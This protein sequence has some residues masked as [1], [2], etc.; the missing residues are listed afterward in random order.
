MLLLMDTQRKQL[1]KR[2]NGLI[3]KSKNARTYFDLNWFDRHCKSYK[4]NRPKHEENYQYCLA[5]SR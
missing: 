5:I 2:E 3:Y 1:D 4:I